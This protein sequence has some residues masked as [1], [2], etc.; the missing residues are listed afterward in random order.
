M[1]SLRGSSGLETKYSA[2]FISPATK[3]TGSRRAQSMTCPV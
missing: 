2:F 3:P 1:S